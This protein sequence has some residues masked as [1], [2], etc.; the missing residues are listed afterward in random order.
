MKTGERLSALLFRAIC[1]GFSTLLLVLTL[2]WQIR[3]TALHSE[4]RTLERELREAED[5][6]V[7]VQMRQSA[8]L[9]LEELERIALQELGMQRPEPGQIIEAQI[10]G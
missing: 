4:L 7:Y 8:Q 2:L 9:T 10:A 3:L 1:L 6:K 5:Q